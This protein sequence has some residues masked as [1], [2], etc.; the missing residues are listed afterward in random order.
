MN[1]VFVDT[2]AWYALVDRRDPDHHAVTEAMR[3]HR[4]LLLTSNFILDETLTLIR[5]RL[6]W[7]IAHRFGEQL[8]SGAVAR[9][10]RISSRDEEAA[11]TIF[12]GYSDK[13]LSFTDCTSFAL[14]G[15]LK[16]KLCIAIDSDFRSYGLH[17][18]P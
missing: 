2:G 7:Q 16:I 14:C 18:V 11:W 1:R 13:S 4:G 6:G 12:A 17:C 8:R 5:F 10:E 3:E 15:R 9:L